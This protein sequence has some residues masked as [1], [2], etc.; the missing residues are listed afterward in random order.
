VVATRFLENVC[1]CEGVGVGCGNLCNV[2]LFN[3]AMVAFVLFL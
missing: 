2:K 1:V 3:R